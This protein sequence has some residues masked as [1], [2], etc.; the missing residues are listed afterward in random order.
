LCEE[1]TVTS[2]ASDSEER[3]ATLEVG[4]EDA[5]LRL[6]EQRRLGIWWQ[7]RER[8]PSTSR[9]VVTTLVKPDP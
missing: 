5:D 7:G 6:R 8:G 4:N 1:T 3:S 2:G 9:K